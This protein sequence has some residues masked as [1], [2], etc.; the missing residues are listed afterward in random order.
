MPFGNSDR[1][2]RERDAM[3]GRGDMDDGPR[4]PKSRPRRGYDD[5]EDFDDDIRV[6]EMGDEE[7]IYSDDEGT[8][9]EL[10][11][12]GP[13]KYMSGTNPREPIDYRG[14]HITKT[15]NGW[16]YVHDSYDGAPE[17]SG[18]PPSDNRCGIAASL[19]DAIA[20]IDELESNLSES[21]M[22]KVIREWEPSFNAAG[23]KPGDYQMPS[24]GGGGVAERGVK[25]DSVGKYDTE[26]SDMGKEW[27]RDHNDTAAMC[28]VDEDGVEHEPQGSHESTHGEPVD[29]HTKKMGHDW[30]ADPKNGGGHLEPFKGSRWSDGGTLTGGSGQDEFSISNSHKMAGEG[31]I[32]GTSGPQLGQPSESWSPEGIGSLMEEDLNLQAIFDSYARQS[33]YICLEEFQ[34]LCRAHGSRLVFD[35]S[36][37]LKLMEQNKEFVFHEGLDASGAYWVGQ[38]AT[39]SEGTIS[40]LQVRSPEMETGLYDGYNPHP[41]AGFPEMDPMSHSRGDTDAELYDDRLAGG[42]IGPDEGG[43]ICDNCGFEAATGEESCPECAAPLG[44]GGMG[45]MDDFPAG[46]DLPSDIGPMGG[47]DDLDLGGDEGP[48]L[49]EIPEST[50]R[51][52]KEIKEALGNFFES[53]DNIIG[54]NRGNSRKSIGE[55]LQY[56]WMVHGEGIDARS[57][58]SNYRTRLAALSRQFPTFRP[59]S[60]NVG[61]DSMG[62]TAIGGGNSMKVSDQLAEEDNPGPDDVKEMGE[63]LGRSQKNT[64]KET[65]TISGTAKG[66]SESARVAKNNI[67]RLAAHVKPMLE[68]TGKTINGEYGMAFTV[69]VKDSK[70]KNRTNVSNSLAEALADAEEILQIHGPKNAILES[71]FVQNGKTIRKTNI[72]LT[73]VAGRGPIISEGKALF[74][75]NRTAESFA[76]SLVNEG[77]ECLITDHNW[78]RAVQAKVDRGTALAAFKKLQK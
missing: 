78:G 22:G 3:L 77:H 36:F 66:M 54:R 30:P 42:P 40:E 29:G 62:G 13:D 14:Y 49:D 75:F 73:T 70:G 52:T 76:S 67:A 24:P 71:Y 1:A 12:L 74:R 61:M 53:A 39:L 60:E 7:A 57:V 18:G 65:P 26:L 8:L 56:A 28:D 2:F 46:G 72:N 51:M 32:T 23:Y 4:P 16:E 38:Q 33:N 6:N 20:D 31:E 44:V 55:A 27:P 45:D 25:K 50:I 48:S 37:L 35:E 68:D 69:L 41:E 15:E 19:D 47:M 59:L 58:G 64:Y 17:H 21:T 11:G 10:G 43:E 63:P 5:D 34:E 9:S